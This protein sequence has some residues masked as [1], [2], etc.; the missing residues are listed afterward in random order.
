MPWRSWIF[1]TCGLTLCV[2]LKMNNN[3]QGGLPSKP[4]EP[5]L[6]GA[7][8]AAIPVWTLGLVFFLN[9]YFYPSWH[10]YGQAGWLSTTQ[11]LKGSLLLESGKDEKEKQRK[12]FV[13]TSSGMN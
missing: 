6:V 10:P 7:Y 12:S 13:T 9:S 1:F 4:V 2:I 5:V 3:E 8:F 11:V